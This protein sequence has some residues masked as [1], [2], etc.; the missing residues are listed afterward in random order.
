MAEKRLAVA[1]ALLAQN[2]GKR[3]DFTIYENP[4]I[5]ND[6]GP[7]GQSYQGTDAPRSPGGDV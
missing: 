2:T 6:A 7:A 1:C 5:V 4:E 3:G